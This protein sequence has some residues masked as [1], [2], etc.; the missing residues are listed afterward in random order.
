MA[1]RASSVATKA[2]PASRAS[3]GQHSPALREGWVSSAVSGRPEPYESRARDG[4][5]RPRRPGGPL[6]PPMI[7]PTPGTD[8]AGGHRDTGGVDRWTPADV[9]AAGVQLGVRGATRY[10]RTRFRW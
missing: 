6:G 4:R 2:R 1:P 8:N 7:S 9:K 5:T 3:A 10:I